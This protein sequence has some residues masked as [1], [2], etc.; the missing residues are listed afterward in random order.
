MWNRIRHADRQSVRLV[1]RMEPVVH[2]HAH[3]RRPHRVH[4]ARQHAVR[5]QLLHVVVS[6]KVLA[7][8]EDLRHRVAPARESAHLVQY[9]L[10]M[11]P[12]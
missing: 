11:I 5:L 10:P 12:A 1:P 6:A 8:E 7:V 9:F 3:R 4:L 2:H